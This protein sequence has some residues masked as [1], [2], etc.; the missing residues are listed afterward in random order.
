MTRRGF[1][2]FL[3]AAPLAFLLPWRK[4]EPVRAHDRIGWIMPNGD[5]VSDV[6]LAD[7]TTVRLSDF[8][9][10]DP[11]TWDVKKYF[12][13]SKVHYDGRYYYIRGRDA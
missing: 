4:R 6:S 11:T 9:V 12:P 3:L 2:K 7:S 13:N 8:V 10:G 5:F 1:F